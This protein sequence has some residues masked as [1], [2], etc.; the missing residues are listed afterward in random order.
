MAFN[1][2]TASTF[3]DHSFVPVLMN[4]VKKGKKKSPKPST[5]TAL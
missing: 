1:Y 4:H 3:S 5:T 2:T